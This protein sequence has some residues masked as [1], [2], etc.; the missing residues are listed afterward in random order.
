MPYSKT[1]PKVPTLSIISPPKTPPFSKEPR[2]YPH[3][4]R[5][6][7]HGRL[8]T[9]AIK[10]AAPIKQPNSTWDTCLL[11]VSSDEEKA[12][13]Q[14]A[15]ARQTLP[16]LTSTQT[17]TTSSA[18]DITARFAALEELKR[19]EEVQS[20]NEVEVLE[21]NAFDFNEL[22]RVEQGIIPVTDYSRLSS[23][24]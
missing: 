4:L 15:H 13:S 23:Q 18:D 20:I 12:R 19:T 14:R 21:G 6:S 10:A 8:S 7:L 24:G 16:V 17:P 3:Y 11:S 2:C 22:D 1:K 9:T 5:V